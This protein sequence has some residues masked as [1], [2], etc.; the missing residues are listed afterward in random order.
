MKRRVFLSTAIGA[1]MA[2]AAYGAVFIRGRDVSY[3]PDQP[4]ESMGLTHRRRPENSR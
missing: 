2:H 4:L 3:E 1:A